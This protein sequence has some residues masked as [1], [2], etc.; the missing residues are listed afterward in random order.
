MDTQKYVAT[1]K[2]HAKRAKHDSYKFRNTQSTS[3]TGGS[4]REPPVLCGVGVGVDALISAMTRLVSAVS[5]N[6]TCSGGCRW[7]LGRWQGWCQAETG[8]V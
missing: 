1:T 4:R 3:G 2:T 5:G 8:V 7:N 6:R